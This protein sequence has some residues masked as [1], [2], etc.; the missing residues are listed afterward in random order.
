[1]VAPAVATI[2]LV[3]LAASG[4]AK[5]SDPAPTTGAM[6]AAGLPAADAV[7][8]VFGLTEIVIAS[9]ALILGGASLV[10]ATL[11]YATF[12]IFTFAALRKR[13][14]VQSCGCFG[15]EDTPPSMV[16]VVFNLVATAALAASVLLGTAP[17]DW[18]TPIIELL[19][20]LGFALVGAYTSYLLM[21]G[22]PQ[23]AELS[24]AR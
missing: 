5:L 23:L 21:T 4:V 10:L 13:I 15:R 7:T 14:P 3:L 11:L 9:L 24:R 8:F 12:S 19:L 17:I 20:Y 2:A 1:V 22:L 16:H 6:R 18:S